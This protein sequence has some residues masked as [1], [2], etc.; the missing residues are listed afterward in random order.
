MSQ[1]FPGL[2][3]FREATLA[4]LRKILKDPGLMIQVKNVVGGAPQEWA[5]VELGAEAECIDGKWDHIDSWSSGNH[6]A[7]PKP[8]ASH[9]T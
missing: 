8:Q 1:T 9:T 7:N 4:R 3:A 2:K 5:C 6:I